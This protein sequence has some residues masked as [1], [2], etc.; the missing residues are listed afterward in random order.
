M[1][2][3]VFPFCATKCTFCS[4]L[5]YLFRTHTTRTFPRTGD[6]DQGR[7]TFRARSPPSLLRERVYPIAGFRFVLAYISLKVARAGA[8]GRLLLLPTNFCFI[9]VFMAFSYSSEIPDV[10]TQCPGQLARHAAPSLPSSVRDLPSSLPQ[11]S[12]PLR[13]QDLSFAP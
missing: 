2:F 3:S 10:N 8:S 11:P 13:P 7:T 6:P 12:V 4:Q 9:S 1:F 5:L